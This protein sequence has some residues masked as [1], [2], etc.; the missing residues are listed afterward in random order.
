MWFQPSLS[1]RPRWA[2][3]T[4]GNGTHLL[5][6]C[7]AGQS[8]ASTLQLSPSVYYSIQ[9]QQLELVCIPLLTCVLLGASCTA[10]RCSRRCGGH[11]VRRPRRSSKSRIWDLLVTLQSC[12]A[13][14][15]RWWTRILMRWECK[16]KISQAIICVIFASCL[17]WGFFLYRCASLQVNAIRNGN[18]KVLNKLMGLVQKETKGRADPVLVRTILQ[19]KTSWKLDCS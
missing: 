6:S 2:A 11:R 4:P 7:Q 18:K 15:R 19:E 13:S 16:C 1:S 5:F 10:L 8:A 3:G 17:K 9:T 14:A 12:T